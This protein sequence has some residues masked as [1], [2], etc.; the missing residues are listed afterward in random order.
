[1][2]KTCLEA[3]N[4]LQRWNSIRTEWEDKKSLEIEADYIGPMQSVLTCMSEKL[5]EINSF[6]DETEDRIKEIKE[7]N[8]Y[9]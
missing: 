5:C 8:S 2:R 3:H 4:Q 6:I 7:E 9:G 1:M